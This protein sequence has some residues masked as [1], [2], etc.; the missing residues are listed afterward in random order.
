MVSIPVA[1]I[2][3]RCSYGA[4]SMP[5]SHLADVSEGKKKKERKEKD[6]LSLSR[7]LRCKHAVKNTIITS[8]I[9]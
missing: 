3:F 9:Q 6:K 5:L 7:T 8:K 4:S 2:K 1:L